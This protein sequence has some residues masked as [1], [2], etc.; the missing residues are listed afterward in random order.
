MMGRK[1]PVPEVEALF[2]QFTQQD[3]FGPH[4]T[5]VHFSV[6]GDERSRAIA[7]ALRS[8]SRGWVGTDVVGWMHLND[9]FG[10]RKLSACQ[11]VVADGEVVCLRQATPDFRNNVVNELADALPALMQANPAVAEALSEGGTLASLVDPEHAS[12]PIGELISRA[13][14]PD[15]LYN[16]VPVR[17]RGQVVGVFCLCFNGLP[18]NQLG[19]GMQAKQD[20]TAE[21]L[22]DIIE[23]LSERHVPDGTANITAEG[24]ANGTADD[25]AVLAIGHDSPSPPPGWPPSA[26]SRDSVAATTLHELS[27]KTLAGAVLQMKSLAGKVVLVLNTASRCGFTPVV[28]TDLAKLHARHGAQLEVLCFPSNE[29]GKQE[30]PSVEIPPVMA[31]YG[32]PT[33]GGGATLMAMVELNGPHTHPIWRLAKQAFPGDIYWNFAGTFLFDQQG[34][35]IGRFRLPSELDRL[36][37][38]IDSLLALAS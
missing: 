8:A 12:G 6:V 30:L 28:L 3:L 17:F 26:R 21:K 20:K 18:G 10:P 13:V 35:P 31:S 37:Q 23:G 34:H 25:T 29:F 2:S 14:L 9:G 38:Q 32:L 22:G 16:G 5:S 19:D 1:L 7:T 36:C 24:T 15:A 4:L 27:A 33:G 11:Y